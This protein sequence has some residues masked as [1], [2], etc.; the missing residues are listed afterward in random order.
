MGESADL[1]T[2]TLSDGAS[3]A[4]RRTPARAAA[5]AS[6]MPGVLFCGGF[7][8]D[9][10]GGKARFLEQHCR[11]HGQGYVRFDYTGHRLSRPQDLALIAAALSDASAAAAGGGSG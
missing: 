4:F 3:I 1:Y 5:G 6:R 8:S 2:L 7:R 9:M 11:R 10:T